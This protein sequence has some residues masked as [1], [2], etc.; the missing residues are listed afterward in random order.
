MPTDRDA[1][2]REAAKLLGQVNQ[3]QLKANDLQRRFTPAPAS[4]AE[5]REQER[6]LN[7]QLEANACD[8]RADTADDPTALIDSARSVAW[9]AMSYPYRV[10]APS[11]LAAEVIKPYA[12]NADKER[13]DVLLVSRLARGILKSTHRPLAPPEA[14]P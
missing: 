9:F 1:K 8:F 6:A 3:L 7:D 12:A 4:A 13:A 2:L 14:T 10:A 11:P 5:V